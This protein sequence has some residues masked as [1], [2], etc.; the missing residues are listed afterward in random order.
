MV[1]KSSQ[2]YPVYLRN[3]ADKFDHNQCVQRLFRD[4]K[5]NREL[6]ALLN[7]ALC[8][9]PDKPVCDS[10]ENV[11]AAN[12]TTVATINDTE[13]T[14]ATLAQ[15]TAETEV[16]TEATF[17]S[18]QWQPIASLQSFQMPIESIR[19]GMITSRVGL[20][21]IAT[22]PHTMDQV[23]QITRVG[24]RKKGH[25]VPDRS[26]KRKRRRCYLCL[27]HGT[28]NQQQNALH[29]KGAH[30][31]KNCPNYDPHGNQKTSNGH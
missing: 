7:E 1:R 28:Y 2:S 22:N 10:S 31:Q 13:T 27:K 6:L 8:D 17:T 30:Y 3:H 26:G 14:G 18:T 24:K 12:A 11:V 23:T 29:C 5:D 20:T 16:P 21:N 9:S 4:A 19:H 15:E 25:R